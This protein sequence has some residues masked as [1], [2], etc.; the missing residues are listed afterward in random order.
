MVT[1]NPLLKRMAPVISTAS[2]ILGPVHTSSFV[3]SAFRYSG[4]G[5]IPEVQRNGVQGEFRLYD[6]DTSCVL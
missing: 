1:R 2:V 5:A 4:A 3:F 6:Y